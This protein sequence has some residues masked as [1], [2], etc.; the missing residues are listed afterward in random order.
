MCHSTLSGADIVES[1]WSTLRTFPA[2]A[3]FFHFLGNIPSFWPSD[4]LGKWASGLRLFAHGG[5]SKLNRCRPGL[6]D[7]SG[8]AAKEQ[9]PANGQCHG[10]RRGCRKQHPPHIQTPVYAGLDDGN[11][12]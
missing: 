5:G 8:L 7:P 12:L 6:R 10:H 11:Y 4:C 2:G 9:N 3:G 1:G